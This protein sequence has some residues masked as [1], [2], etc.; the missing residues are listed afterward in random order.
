LYNLRSDQGETTNVADKFPEIVAQIRKL[1]EKE[2]S[3]L[4]EYSSK[5]PE[6]RKTIFVEFPEPLIKTK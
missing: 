5:G 3:A 6:V 4:G 2:K 1:A